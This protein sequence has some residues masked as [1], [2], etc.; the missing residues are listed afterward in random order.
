E[1]VTPESFLDPDCRSVLEPIH[2]WLEEGHPFTMD[3]ALAEIGPATAKSLACDL[4]LVGERRAASENDALVRL[5]D[6]IDAFERIRRAQVSVSNRAGRPDRGIPGPGDEPGALAAR[7]QAIRNRGRDPT[8][9]GRLPGA[10][11]HRGAGP[12]ES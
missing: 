8:A 9:Y 10:S 6:A 11:G 7:L 12:P 3:E 2:L 4:V 1:A 5:Q